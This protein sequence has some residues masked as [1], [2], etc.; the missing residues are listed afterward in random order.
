[1]GE[2]VKVNN[3]KAAKIDY[4]P[5][6]KDT[7]NDFEKLFGKRGAFCG[8]WCMYWRLPKKQFTAN[9]GEANKL[10]FKKIVEQ[11]E[12]PG[13]I[14][15]LDGVPAGWV[16]ISPRE[17]LPGL[18][19][20]KQ[21][22]KIDDKTVWSIICFYV[23]K[24]YRGKGLLKNLIKAAVNFARENGAKIVESYPV[25]ENKKYRPVT[26]HQGVKTTFLKEGFNE[27]ANRNGKVIMR[28]YIN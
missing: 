22:K 24:H 12:K 19:S 15:Y 3:D 13:I 17:K 26:I 1:M 27:V 28:Y 2:L 9:Q 16:S 18:E 20:S 23:E 6:I 25:D 11:G 7:W 4:K 14:A 10:M 21:L 5:L 8:C